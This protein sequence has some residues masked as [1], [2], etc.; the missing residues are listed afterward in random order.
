[1]SLLCN[2]CSTKIDENEVE[3]HIST[4]QHIEN[5]LKI[6]TNGKGLDKSVASMWLKSLE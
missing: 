4:P 1:M 2:I 3:L 6:T 5:K